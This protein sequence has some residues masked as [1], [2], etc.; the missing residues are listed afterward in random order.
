MT[1]AAL[2]AEGGLRRVPLAEAPRE[3]LR[4]ACAEDTDI[5]QIYPMSFFGDAFDPA[6][7]KCLRPGSEGFAAII[8]DELVGM[9]SYLDIDEKHKSVQIGRTYFVPRLRGTGFNRRVKRL[10]LDRAFE[11]GFRRVEFKV[12]TRNARSMAAIA[13]L[14]A[15]HEGTLRQNLITW[16]G[17]VRDT[18]VYS[19]LQGEWPALRASW[20]S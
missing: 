16:T 1:L 12:D 11:A 2:M 13:K 6:F 4:R 20:E 8:G 3:A 15:V 10:M 19:I 9:S 5:W 7:D 17:Y 18:A 14:G